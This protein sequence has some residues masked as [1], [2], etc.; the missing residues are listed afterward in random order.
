MNRKELNMSKQYDVIEPRIYV[1]DVQR[2]FDSLLTPTGRIYDNDPEGVLILKGRQPGATTIVD[3][4]RRMFRDDTVAKFAQEH[5]RFAHFANAEKRLLEYVTNTSDIKAKE[6]AKEFTQKAMLDALNDWFK[7]AKQHTFFL[8]LDAIHS[9]GIRME[10]MEPDS[11]SHGFLL[12]NFQLVGS[13]N[14][15]EKQKDWSGVRSKGRAA[16][17]L[18]R[19]HRQNIRTIY[20]PQ[21]TVIVDKG[22]RTI[23]GHPATIDALVKH[24][25]LKEVI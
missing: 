12:S 8:G 13:T 25:K 11:L 22:R 9:E 6:I 1:D 7:T 3:E 24:I 4:A 21:K 5:L 23:I 18:A 20:V 10:G 15:V 19:G 17:R 16:R 14:M 2:K